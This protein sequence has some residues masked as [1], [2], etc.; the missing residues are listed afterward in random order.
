MADLDAD[1]LY[2]AM[3]EVLI[4]WGIEFDPSVMETL[5][6]RAAR[7]QCTQNPDVALAF[8]QRALKWAADHNT[9]VLAI[10][11]YRQ[12]GGSAKQ[13]QPMDSERHSESDRLA[14]QE[15]LTFL[16]VDTRI[17]L[18]SSMYQYRT[19]RASKQLILLLSRT[20]EATCAFVYVHARL[21]QEG[22]HHKAAVL[23]VGVRTVAEMYTS[24][25]GNGPGLLA[26]EAIADA[27]AVKEGGWS[28]TR[29]MRDHTDEP[30]SILNQR[31]NPDES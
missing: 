8:Q 14:R 25:V 29:V 15:E 1:V 28:S 31:I 13:D 26:A 5:W 22:G 3:L 17:D 27:G 30:W 11:L 18:W 16:Q 6:V 20:T 9:P 23:F 2:L 21:A 19:R 7:H 24:G 12:V 4:R 10:E